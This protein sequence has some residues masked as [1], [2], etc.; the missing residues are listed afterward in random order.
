[1]KI[2]ADKNIPYLKGVAEQYGEVTYLDG[3]AFTH[4]A[5]KEA[6]TLIVRTVTRFDE[7]N[8]K[9]TNVKLIC[10]ATIGYDHIDTGY[11]DTHSIAWRNAPGCN[12]G[13]VMQYIISSLIVISRKKG[14]SLKDKTIGIVGVGNVGK[15]V[16]KACEILGLKVLLNDPPRQKSENSISFVDL[17]T[18]INEADIITFHT[19]LAKEGEYKAYHLADKAFFSSLKRKP[20]II[21]SARGG[22]ID[23]EA[24]KKAIRENKISGAIIDCWENEPQIDTEYMNLADIA[25]PHIAGYSA[26]GKANA[27]RMSLE[28]IAD[29]YRMSKE[30]VSQIMV[31]EPEN[32]VI[33]LEIFT[34]SDNKVYDTILET[35]NPMDDFS[36]LKAS[37]GTFKQL[38]N[39]YPLRREYFT[40]RLKN[41]PIEDEIVLK[42]LG[43]LD[44]S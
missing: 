34:N 44:E 32:A 35:Y 38:R 14:F 10:S 17:D 31:P 40:Y 3:A 22:I 37:P 19:P 43:F 15:K 6:D 24:I 30:P 8:L 1:M 41:A 4:E 26:D 12:S 29:F 36:H 18:I 5:I 2:I 7:T 42:D 13:S 16:A 27:T 9:G 11:C 20:I 28:S 39:S 23:T 21:N 25:T 33:D